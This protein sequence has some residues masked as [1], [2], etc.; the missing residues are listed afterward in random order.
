MPNSRN[1]PHAI[2]ELARERKTIEP[3]ARQHT[4]PC[5]GEAQL[6]NILGQIDGDRDGLMRFRRNIH[7]GLLS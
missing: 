5:I 6:E 4:E 2:L 3:L 7:G 1:K